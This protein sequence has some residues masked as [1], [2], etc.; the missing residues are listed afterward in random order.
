MGEIS[1]R[2]R[3]RRLRTTLYCILYALQAVIER[4]CDESL[5]SM[6][7]ELVARKVVRLKQDQ[8]DRWLRPCEVSWFQ[9]LKSS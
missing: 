6:H 9:G 1:V 7:A 8:P 5:V 2:C 4:G 3:Q